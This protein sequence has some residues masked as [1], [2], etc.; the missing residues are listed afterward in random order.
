MVV[1][2]LDGIVVGNGSE[3]VSE[4]QL[5]HY[6]SIEYLPPVEAGQRY[7]MEASAKGAIVLWTRGFGPHRSEA[8]DPGGGDD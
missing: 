6:E 4:M 8:R 7:G 5:G 3:L 1:V 2:V